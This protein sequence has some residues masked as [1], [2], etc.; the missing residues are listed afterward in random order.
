[1][2]HSA[3]ARLMTQPASIDIARLSSSGGPKSRIGGRLV[4]TWVPAPCPIA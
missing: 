1:M 3:T 2:I 4:K